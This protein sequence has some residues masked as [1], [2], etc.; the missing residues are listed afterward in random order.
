[1]I[2]YSLSGAIG[3]GKFVITGDPMSINPIAILRGVKVAWDVLKKDK[4]NNKQMQRKILLYNLK[5]EYKTLQ[6]LILLD[7]CIYYTNQINIINDTILKKI[8]REN[9][10]I[11]DAN[12]K[13][14]EEINQ[15]LIEYRKIH[16][17]YE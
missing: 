7:K 2:S 5:T 16:E 4:D 8:K 1:M 17:S 3:A 13:I 12:K 14:E 6:T 10:E 9:V 11:E 15:D